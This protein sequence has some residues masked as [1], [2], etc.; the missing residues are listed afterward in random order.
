MTLQT[1]LSMI[2]MTT[3]GMPV[4]IL[5]FLILLTPLAAQAADF[6]T[7]VKPFVTKYC[8]KCHQGKE[9]RGQL[10]LKSIAAGDAA[11]QYKAWQSVSEVLHSREMPPED[12]PQPS[13][14]ERLKILD[15]YSH[16]LVKSVKPQPATASSAAFVCR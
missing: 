10:D 3:I 1:R 16:T 15:W 7:D 6:K 5:T 14:Q 9:A 12:E 11:K 8:V 13:E 2:L 4:R